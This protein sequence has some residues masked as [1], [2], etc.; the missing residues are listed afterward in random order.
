M[1]NLQ[2]SKSHAVGKKEQLPVF[3]FYRGGKL[4]LRKWKHV[5]MDGMP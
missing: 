1:L 4:R 5:G 2:E 3:P